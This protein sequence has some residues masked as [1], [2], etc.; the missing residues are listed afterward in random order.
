MNI[1]DLQIHCERIDNSIDFDFE[2]NITWNVYVLGQ[3]PD[4]GKNK[5]RKPANEEREDHDC[6]GEGRLP[7][8]SGVSRSWQYRE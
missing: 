6:H 7:L 2:L 8:L 1:W 4:Q 3:G 5:E